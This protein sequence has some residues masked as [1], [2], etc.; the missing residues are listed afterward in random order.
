MPLFSVIIPTYN[1]AELLRETLNSVF[2]QNFKDFEVV[3]VD[4]GST[5]Q[6]EAVVRSFGNGTRFIR[7]TN[8][9]PGV[10]RNLGVQESTGQFITFLDSDD[11]WFPWTLAAYADVL[12]SNNRVELI[13]GKAVRFSA[14]EDLHS[15]RESRVQISEYADFLTAGQ[16]PLFFG[17][18][19]AVIRRLLL[20]GGG[21][22][23]GLRVFEDQDL[24]IRLGI[25]AV[26]AV[27]ES[28]V[29][30]AYRQTPG[31]LTTCSAWAV[32]GISYLIKS[33]K[34]GIY[35]GGSRRRWDRRNYICFSIRSLSI[36]L[37]KEAKLKDA[38][39]LYRQSLF[40]H[41]R[42][43]RFRYVA[44]F[45]LLLAKRLVRRGCKS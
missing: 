25:G 15:Q 22:V 32:E 42:L 37:L 10:A 44:G 11:L 31:S 12:R 4:D 39:S 26:C 36:G 5:D 9:G 2:A 30:V 29:T 3:V 35:P 27:V 33:E 16:K 20:K 13:L 18:N 43:G 6:T 23:E 17:S 28:P 41:L 38:W 40:W 45:P 21:F 14:P 1:R 7:Q 34:A 19:C 24:G 8:Q